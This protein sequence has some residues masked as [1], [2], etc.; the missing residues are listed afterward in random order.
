MALLSIIKDIL[1]FSKLEAGKF[2]L[3][4]EAFSPREVLTKTT[5]LFMPRANEKGL[6]FRSEIHDAIPDMVFGH[7]GRFQQILVNLVWNVLKFTSDG[8]IGLKARVT[9]QRRE[10]T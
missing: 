5:K 8:Y 1:D 6:E 3:D 4:V 7:S 10:P 2:E 9:Y